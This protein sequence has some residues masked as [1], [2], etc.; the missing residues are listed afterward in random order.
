MKPS[1][2]IG[3]MSKKNEGDQQGGLVLTSA[4]KFEGMLCI[5]QDDSDTVTTSNVSE[6]VMRER[7]TYRDTS[8]S[9]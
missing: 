9:G 7:V 4:P 8:T 6:S 1:L 2:V 3:S 5:L